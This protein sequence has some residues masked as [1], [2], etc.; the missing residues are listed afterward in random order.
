MRLTKN[1]KNKYFI[2]INKLKTNSSRISFNFG[3]VAIFLLT[4]SRY[5][6]PRRE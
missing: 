1:Q 4:T 5:L 2:E 3:I 6:E